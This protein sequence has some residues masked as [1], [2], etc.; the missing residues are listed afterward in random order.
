MPIFWKSKTLLAKVEATYGTDAVPVA[1]T[2]AI[3]ATD[4]TF[5]PM[6]GEDVE[7]NLEL[8][9]MGASSSLPAGV[10]SKLTFSVE[11]AGSG[12]LGVA[13]GWGP[14]LRMCGVAE[15]ITAATKVEY[16]PVSTAHSS[17]T[18]YFA[19]G[20]TRH[21]MT[22][23]RGTA[24]VKVSAQGIPMLM[25]T[26][27]GLFAVPTTQAVVSPNLSA[28]K[29][30]VIASKA[31]TPTF[32]ISAAAFVLREFEFDLGCDVQMRMLMGSEGAVIVDKKEGVKTTVEAVDL[33]TY[34]PFSVSMGQAMK[35]LQLIHGTAAGLRVQIDIAQATQ[36]RLSAYQQQQNILEWPLEFTPLQNAGDDQWKLTLN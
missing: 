3:L 18:I 35:S 5:S 8:P 16:N 22:G 21:V 11:L 1:A 10:Y 17:G 23:V 32:T 29:A 4:V 2:N 26:L 20:T 6:E 33:A 15:T 24:T 28:F 13:P 36:K 30:P 14:L 7:R 31:N 27:W 9:K 12:T 34:D 25:F 19:I